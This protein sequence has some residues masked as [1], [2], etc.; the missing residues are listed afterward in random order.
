[1]S[2]KPGQSLS[3][4]PLE[5]LAGTG[6]LRAIRG[7]PA[8]SSPAIQGQAKSPD[9]PGLGLDNAFYLTYIMKDAKT[10]APHADR[11]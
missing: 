4:R 10:V 3:W 2:P 9:G 1:M 5:A 6:P 11:R 7:V 8:Q